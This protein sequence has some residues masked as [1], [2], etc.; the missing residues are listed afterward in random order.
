MLDDGS[1]TVIDG[2]SNSATGIY[3]G[4]GDPYAVAVNAETNRIYVANLG[5]SVSVIDG[6]SDTL[7]TNVTVGVYPV[8]ALPSIRSSNQIYV[9]QFG[10]GTV[11]VIDGTSNTATSVT[12]GDSPGP[13][14]V[15]AADQQDLCREL[16]RQ[17][18]RARW[19]GATR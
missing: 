16:C 2:A 15:M 14:S 4:G 8:R 11:S 7:I 12:V 18:D 9:S 19:S 17:R 10:D 1:V 6:A 5:D 13:L 3:T